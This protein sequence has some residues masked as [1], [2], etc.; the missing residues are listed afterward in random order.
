MV[1]EY[2]ITAVATFV[3]VGGGSLNEPQLLKSLSDARKH[4]PAVLSLIE[5]TLSTSAKSD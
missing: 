2:S 1:L 3:F 5:S 4:T